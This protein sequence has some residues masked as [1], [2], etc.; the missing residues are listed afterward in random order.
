MIKALIFDLDGTLLD[1][2][3]DLAESTNHVLRENGYPE[4]PLEE[5]NYLV[6]QGVRHLIEYALPDDAR[7]DK[8][9]DRLV[10][11]FREYYGAHWDIHT[12]PYPGIERMLDGLRSTKRPI[13]VLSN[14]P[15]DFTVMCVEKLLPAVPFTIVMGHKDPFPRKPDPASA[16]YIAEKLGLKP[17]EI[18]FCGDTSIDMTTATRAGMYPVGV[19]W[20]FRPREE[21]LENGARELAD[22]PEDVLRIFKKA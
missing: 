14:K 19:T 16:W 3:R 5:Y 2:L 17:S 4:R 7:E 18:M 9:V 8:R 6:G 12:R 20:G 22:T 13:S 15:H 21:L 11:A 1:T 10:E